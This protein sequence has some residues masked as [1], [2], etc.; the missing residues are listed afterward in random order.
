MKVK[1][2]SKGVILTVSDFD[3]LLSLNGVKYYE[4]PRTKLSSEIYEIK[5]DGQLEIGDD[6][7]DYINSLS[8]TTIP[9]TP[10]TYDLTLYGKVVGNLGLNAYDIPYG[11][12]GRNTLI[13]VNLKYPEAEKIESSVWP[14]C[15]TFTFKPS[16]SVNSYTVNF[17]I[18]EDLR[19]F[20]DCDAPFNS[21]HLH[22]FDK[23]INGK[24]EI[25]IAWSPVEGWGP[26]DELFTIIFKN[27]ERTEYDLEMVNGSSEML[28]SST[29]SKR[30]NGSGKDTLWMNR[31]QLV[32]FECPNLDVLP[33]DAF[34]HFD[35]L[36]S[37]S[38]ENVKS[39]GVMAFYRS[40]LCKIYAPNV[41]TIGQLAFCD[42]LVS[43]IDFPKVKMLHVSSEDK[44]P[45]LHCPL[46]SFKMDG[47]KYL[48]NDEDEWFW[49]MPPPD[50]Y[51]WMRSH[52]YIYSPGALAT[53]Y[54]EI[55]YLKGFNP[56]YQASGNG[57]LKTI[58][59][60]S[61][62]GGTPEVQDRDLFF[63]VFS[64][65]YDTE[66]VYFPISRDLISGNYL[67]NVEEINV[68]SMEKIPS[69]FAKSLSS[70]KN[71]VFN[72][73]LKCVFNRGLEGCELLSGVLS[74]DKIEYIGYRAFANCKNITKVVFPNNFIE[75]IDSEAFADCDNLEKIEGPRCVSFFGRRSSDASNIAT[76]IFAGTKVKD[77][78]Y[79][80]IAYNPV[81]FKYMDEGIFSAPARDILG[82][83]VTI[84]QNRKTNY[85]PLPNEVP[86]IVIHSFI[87][88][89][90]PFITYLKRI[91]NDLGRN[92]KIAIPQDIYA[93]YILCCEN[94][95]Y[96]PGYDPSLN[97][98]N[99]TIQYAQ[100]IE[101]KVD[102]GEPITDRERNILSHKE[103][104]SN[105]SYA[106]EYVRTHINEFIPTTE[107]D[108][109]VFDLSASITPTIISFGKNKISKFE[110]SKKE[111]FSFTPSF[112]ESWEINPPTAPLL[113]VSKVYDDDFINE[114]VNIDVAMAD[115]GRK[116]DYA[117][118]TIR[119]ID[120]ITKNTVWQRMLSSV[121][122]GQ[123]RSV[124]ANGVESGK[125]YTIRA[126][127]INNKGLSA[128]AV[129]YNYKATQYSKGSISYVTASSK[130]STT[131]TVKFNL[132]KLP[133]DA[134][135]HTFNPTV[136]LY[137]K[138]SDGKVSKSNQ[139]LNAVAN[140]EY[141]VN[142]TVEN[143]KTYTITAI[144]RGRVSSYDVSYAT[145]FTHKVTR[146]LVFASGDHY[147][148]K[149]WQFTQKNGSVTKTLVVGKAYSF[150]YSEYGYATNTNTTIYGWTTTKN[151]YTANYLV[152]GSIT[153]TDSSPAT[154]TLYPVPGRITISCNRSQ[155]LYIR[156]TTK[157]NSTATNHNN[158]HFSA[159][160]TGLAE[161]RTW[162][163][164]DL[165]INIKGQRSAAG[166]TW[167]E[168][169]DDNNGS[170]TL[171]STHLDSTSKTDI[172]VL[173]DSGG[174][175]RLWGAGRLYAERRDPVTA[176]ITAEYKIVTG[177]YT[178]INQ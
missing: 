64:T 80:D 44:T 127:A 170:N 10:E 163:A 157:K 17:Q 49:T 77:F 90:S 120:D 152:N 103:E 38:S 130:N 174:N 31:H 21:D 167:F 73:D 92:T 82:T 53:A 4:N 122:S 142:F 99:A 178:Y 51:F 79:D 172:S 168:F 85:K 108:T 2:T 96:A 149:E 154:T 88:Y 138:S 125:Q 143:D 9:F 22:P 171:F 65:L 109:S 105:Y 156:T 1:T 104:M 16:P 30:E 98:L 121:Q 25:G 37:F 23:S 160:S 115:A 19:I 86:G 46:S 116:S 74:F 45:F 118:L 107:D 173:A 35:N 3:E 141:T 132:S 13:K 126:M 101:R 119:I 155:E 81:Q 177:F 159:I 89:M 5:V 43:E 140:N 175:I 56:I 91:D 111:F 71:I 63:D 33:S 102:A 131:V 151:S 78:Y 93:E 100:R 162:Y 18:S 41:E 95:P 72:K 139:T 134:E 144:E 161:S 176:D 39:I 169:R 15:G 97:E 40:D 36:T 42:T 164:Y 32:S 84:H 123:T 128:D 11:S 7:R 110:T 61:Y 47:L 106:M 58:S 50:R 129:Y 26:N 76:N 27:E 6:E 68:Q 112:I 158:F 52:G 147:S 83:N 136:D 62:N 12:Y 48:I 55:E 66:Y 135:G 24:N 150:N 34:V 153:L 8:D 148:G 60:K 114:T 69:N 137:I 146:N 54:K 28:P 57:Q 29:I 124:L 117:D 166:D 94:N 87:G 67:A 59:L 70:V 133:T 145:T 165:R 20:T 113:S 14:I 75:T